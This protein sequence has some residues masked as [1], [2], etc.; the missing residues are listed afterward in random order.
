[1]G[2]QA[3]VICVT[4]MKE[5]GKV[6]KKDLSSFVPQKR[7]MSVQNLQN[8]HMEK[9]TSHTFFQME[10]DHSTF[11][12]WSVWRHTLFLLPSAQRVCVC[13]QHSLPQRNFEASLPMQHSFLSI[14]H[15]RNNPP[16]TRANLK[17]SCAKSGVSCTRRSN[18]RK[19][20]FFKHAGKDKCTELEEFC[21]QE[22]RSHACFWEL[23]LDTQ[24]QARR[25]FLS[26]Q[27]IFPLLVCSS[28]RLG[29]LTFVRRM[30]KTS[31][32]CCLL[33]SQQASQPLASVASLPVA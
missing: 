5:S 21:A 4:F 24:M 20:D 32:W 29:W 22:K 26:H 7:R 15:M 28:H 3:G 9:E 16:H 13:G 18:Q 25:H 27:R 11:A 33:H 31:A 6:G 12:N 17:L 14:V 2:T 8:G 10:I 30:L 1:M 23:E 19:H